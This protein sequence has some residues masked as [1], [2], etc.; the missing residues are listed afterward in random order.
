MKRP[1]GFTLIE[2]LVVISIISILCTIMLPS[3]DYAKRLAREVTCRGGLHAIAIGWKMYLNDNQCQLPEAAGLPVAPEDISIANV[4]KG[5]V[6]DKSNWR[7]PSDDRDYFTTYGISYEYYPGLLM[8]ANPTLKP[9]LE[10]LFKVEEAPYAIFGDAEPFHPRAGVPLGRL[11]VYQD[12]RVD[13]LEIEVAEEQYVKVK[14][15]ET[16]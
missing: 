8:T 5:Y 10:D 13:I 2:L 4:L 3:L 14:G 1:K 11:C 6:N 7:C 9:I 16:P 15:M 12:G